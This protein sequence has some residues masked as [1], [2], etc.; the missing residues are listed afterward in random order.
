MA[1]SMFITVENVRAM[2]DH[3]VPAH[4]FDVRTSSEFIAEHINGFQN[5]PLDAIAEQKI[6]LEKNLP[7]ILVCTNGKKARFAAAMLA[8]H[9]CTDVRIVAGGI[10]SWKVQVFPLTRG[11]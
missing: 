3:K 4:Y 9:G 5:I 10:L 11:A 7:I 8:E 1:E 6:E 2:I